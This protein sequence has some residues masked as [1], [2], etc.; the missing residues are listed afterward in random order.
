M[1]GF[2]KKLLV[3]LLSAALFIPFGSGNKAFAEDDVSVYI[4]YVKLETDQP[5][6][7][8][9]S[10]T[11]VPL[12]GIFEAIKAKVTWDD[13]TRTVTA[14]R[15][16]T[17]VKLEI[18]KNIAFI[19]DNE[20]VLDAVPVIQNGR[21]LV[22]LRF[23]SEA[24]G[25]DVGWDAESKKAT[26]Y[27]KTTKE[28]QEALNE[29]TEYM[30]S[31]KRLQWLA[32]L[33][34]TESGGFYYA[35]S[36]RDNYPFLPD[37]EST[38]QACSLLVNMGV[39]KDFE[40][41]KARLPKEF[42]EKMVNFAREMQSEDD[43][44]FYHP[45][46]GK[47][48]SVSRQG[49]DL[50]H[51]KNIIKKFGNGEFKYPLPE[52]RKNPQE[53]NKAAADNL[54]S[55]AEEFLKS[56]E[57]F[58]DWLQNTLLWDTA[59]HCYESSNTLAATYQNIKAAGYSDV[60]IDFLKSIQNQQTGLWGSE[61][62]KDLT[63]INSDAAMKACLCFYY[64]KV[65][66]PFFEKIFDSVM[67]I[68]ENC[69]PRSTSS[70]YNTWTTLTVA[71]MSL[72]S[73][74]DDYLKNE[75]FKSVLK[76]VPKLIRST[77]EKNEV[78]VKDDGG[79][80]YLPD[81]SSAASQ[82]ASVGLG[83]AEGDVNGTGTWYNGRLQVFYFLNMD[84]IEIPPV[85]T[86]EDRD[87]FI[88][89]IKNAK[90]VQKKG[91]VPAEKSLTLSN[92]KTI[93][94]EAYKIGE[95]IDDNA[96]YSPLV[97][98]KSSLVEISKDPY[99]KKN[100]CLKISRVPS[101]KTSIEFKINNKSTVKQI[102]LEYD[103]MIDEYSNNGGKPFWLYLSPC[104]NWIYDARNDGFTL[105]QRNCVSPEKL[106]E[107]FGLMDFSD[108]THFKIVYEETDETE[109]GT[110]VTYYINGKEVYKSD[111]YLAES[112]TSTTKRLPSKVTRFTVTA[113]PQSKDDAVLYL[114]N[115]KIETK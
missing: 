80:S 29:Y 62:G 70:M 18:G 33:Y 113:S 72:S 68:I 41:M 75:T 47:D 106:T 73:D 10:R 114:D 96:L 103:L 5:A 27:Y 2:L 23:I 74:S 19:N 84:G 48:I 87:A 13:E 95:A 78:F 40:D 15:R 44:Y 101:A 79:C 25:F 66:V 52:E 14:V 7:I 37:L 93:D 21:T 3:I 88:E 58:K 94:F 111:G 9:N 26:V 82:Q 54:K 61:T 24:F 77:M 107:K 99:N 86:E 59:Q 112:D 65:P 30:H 49:R 102:S 20:C 67:Y 53:A 42:S 92:G 36:S 109:S 57:N 28:I 76:K 69:S 32:S 45:Q 4:D 64:A 46:W 51:A 81:K 91:G 110:W 98:D 56:E 8:L 115:I 39:F 22:P 12:R 60:A 85:Y 105:I 1:T 11:M 6:I 71:R 63:T 108:W 50:G 100:K 35:V 43:G 38:Y 34:D 31:F 97:A 16:D 104:Q 83:L 90:P 17:T 89:L 55:G